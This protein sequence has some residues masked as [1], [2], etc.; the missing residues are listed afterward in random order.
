MPHSEEEVQKEERG[1]VTSEEEQRMVNDV[2]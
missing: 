2:G 1:P